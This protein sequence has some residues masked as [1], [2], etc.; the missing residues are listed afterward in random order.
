MLRTLHLVHPCRGRLPQ[1]GHSDFSDSKNDCAWMMQCLRQLPCDS[2]LYTLN[3][4]FLDADIDS[5]HDIDWNQ[6]REHLSHLK[7]SSLLEIHIHMVLPESYPWA[8][9]DVRSGW[10]RGIECE[11]F[12]KGELSGDCTARGISLS[13]HLIY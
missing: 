7:Y 4:G 8:S 10:E 9:I 5:L 6:L 3:L 12:V 2:R 1:Y 13:F 11:N